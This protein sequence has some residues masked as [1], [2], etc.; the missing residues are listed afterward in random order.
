[1]D[2]DGKPR[3]KEWAMTKRLRHGVA[4][5]ALTVAAVAVGCGGGGGSGSGDVAKLDAAGVEEQAKDITILVDDVAPGLSWDGP[6]VALSQTHF[7]FNQLYARLVEHPVTYKADGSA[8]SNVDEFVGD[9]A[10]SWEQ[11][12]NTWTFKLREGVM[13]CAGNELT[14]EDVVYTYARA[15]AREG[16]GPIAWSIYTLAGVFDAADDSKELKG[17]VKALDKYTVQINQVKPQLLFLPALQVITSP[18]LDSKELAKHDTPDDPGGHRWTDSQGAAGFGPYCLKSWSKGS[19][20]VYERNAEWN[21]APNPQYETV[22]VK[23]V[24]SA[25]NRST[26]LQSGSAEIVTGLATRQIAAVEGTNGIEVAESPGTA[27]T[28]LHMNYATEPWENVKLRQAV[29]YMLPYDDIVENG[30]NGLA[31]RWEGIPASVAPNFKANNPYEEDPDKARKLLAEAGYPEGKGLEEFASSFELAY[32]IERA[33]QLRPVATIIAS[34]LQE[35]GLPVKLNP[36][37]LAVFG[38]RVQVKHDLPFAVN[39]QSIPII[40]DAGYAMNVFL[41]PLEKGGTTYPVNYPNE[42]VQDIWLEEALH[43]SDPG[44]RDEAINRALDLAMEDVAVLPIVENP[45]LF[46]HRSSVT[47]FP[48]LP[49]NTMRLRYLRV[50]GGTYDENG[51]LEG[52]TTE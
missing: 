50:A 15:K 44:K 21:V 2:R 41:I 9:L 52:A 43:E 45:A 46:P 38:D 12:G 11:K 37:P 48:W 47:G 30:F 42:K 31:K 23:K 24:P 32:P 10:E 34:A 33:D 8:E 7:G 26:A 5:A 28:W 29:G 18:I 40:P 39:D 1:M 49:D 25:A 17:E 4:V 13:S 6:S 27:G 19:E 16:A 22:T 3:D 14:A 51:E 35:Y 36:I 20:I